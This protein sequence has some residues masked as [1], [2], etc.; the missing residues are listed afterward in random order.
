[1]TETTAPVHTGPGHHGPG[2][3]TCQAC[4]DFDSWCEAHCY[5]CG[6]PRT[7]PGP[8]DRDHVLCF[9]VWFDL[10]PELQA[11]LEIHPHDHKF[12]TDE[13]AVY[14]ELDGEPKRYPTDRC[15]I[16]GESA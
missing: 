4:P 16:C 12:L 6:E 8:R 11:K 15:Y 10:T 5:D 14:G 1:M 13:Q 2:N 3:N 9:V 7:T